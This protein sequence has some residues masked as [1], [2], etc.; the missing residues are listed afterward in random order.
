MVYSSLLSLNDLLVKNAC[1]CIMTVLGSV[2]IV[3]IY[4]LLGK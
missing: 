3:N 4:N 1:E 2:P